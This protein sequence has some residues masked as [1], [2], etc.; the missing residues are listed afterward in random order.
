[1]VL[2]FLAAM[3]PN[4]PAMYRPKLKP[5]CGGNSQPDVAESTAWG[6]CYYRPELVNRYISF[7]HEPLLPNL[8]L[9]GMKI[10]L[11]MAWGSAT[12]V[13]EEVFQRPGLR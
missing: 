1:M 9:R 2:S 4:F 11:D 5:L 3:E 13:A 7:L 6:Q 8:D 10:V 12:R